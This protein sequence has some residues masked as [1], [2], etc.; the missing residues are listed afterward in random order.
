MGTDIMKKKILVV[1]DD[2]ALR[3]LY[4]EELKKEGYEVATA[5]DATKALSYLK[6]EKPDLI[7]LDIIMPGMTGMEAIGPILN[8]HR[9]VPIILNTSHPQY[10]ED[11]G[12]W[13][14]DAYVVK[15]SDLTEL[16]E[17]IRELL[18][19]SHTP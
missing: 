1:E 5:E 12:S 11:L 3:L 10:Q 13:G 17:R 6:N 7:V 18:E 19:K 15:S 4:N 8:E 14:A 16:K 2:D 9:K